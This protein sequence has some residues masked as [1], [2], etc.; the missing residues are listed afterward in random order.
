MFSRLHD[1]T[2]FPV[3]FIAVGGLTIFLI[4]KRTILPKNLTVLSGQTRTV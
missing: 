2:Y 4:K 3:Y 1:Y